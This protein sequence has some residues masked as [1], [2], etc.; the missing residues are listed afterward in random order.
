MV[1]MM[2]CENDGDDGEADSLELL[3]LL[4][5]LVCDR[6]GERAGKLVLLNMVSVVM[7]PLFCWC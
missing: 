3:S 7:V 1:I 5:L 4:L 2:G 6:G